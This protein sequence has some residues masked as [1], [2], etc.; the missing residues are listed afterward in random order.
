MGEQDNKLEDLVCHFTKLGGPELHRLRQ[1]LLTKP[2]WDSRK[3]NSLGKEEGK[4][5]ANVM[6]DS[7]TDEMP[8]VSDLYV[9]QMKAKAQQ[10]QPHPVG[11]PPIK[12]MFLMREYTPIELI[13]TV[14]KV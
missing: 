9:I 5:E 1:G 7:K 11:L 3:W 2:A 4:E 13:D 10:Q 6:I 8:H 12:K 14:A